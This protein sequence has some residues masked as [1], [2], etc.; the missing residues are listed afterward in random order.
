MSE[1]RTEQQPAWSA[2]AL[3]G[4]RVER[5][6]VVVKADLLPA[7]SVV[8]FVALLG[9]PVG[10]LWSL[11]A[12]PQRM[13]VMGGEAGELPLQ[14]ESWHRFDALAVFLLLGLAA[15]IAVGVV[16]W[17]LR[18]RRGPVILVA[19]V[20]GSV[21]SAW[22]AMQ[23]GLS[24]AGSRYAITD[25]PEVGAVVEAAPVLETGWAVLAQPLTTALVYGMLAIW[26]S[27]DDLGRR[28]G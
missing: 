21:V 12:P 24:F 6:K 27:R 20:L 18:E 16:V 23:M 3:E 15:G 11:L 13:R 14:L 1:Q 4:V 9:I 26:N 10:W 25:P 2:L 7:I 28:L 19:A 17:L 22:L 8:S 5:P